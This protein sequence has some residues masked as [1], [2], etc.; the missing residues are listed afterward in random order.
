MVFPHPCI[1]VCQEIFTVAVV[2]ATLI[3]VEVGL[4]FITMWHLILTIRLEMKVLENNG[5]ETLTL[6]VSEDFSWKKSSKTIA[7]LKEMHTSESQSV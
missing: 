6:L 3:T 7:K 2:T 5:I 4:H 1:F